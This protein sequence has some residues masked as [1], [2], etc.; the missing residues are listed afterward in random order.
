MTKALA[1]GKFDYVIMHVWA[2]QL[3]FIVSQ[4]AA[5]NPRIS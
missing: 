3:D 5:L 1:V 2:V 4:T